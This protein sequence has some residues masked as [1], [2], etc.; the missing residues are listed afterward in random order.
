MSFR[1]WDH[2]AENLLTFSFSRHSHHISSISSSISN[3]NSRRPG[4]KIFKS[5]SHL[6]SRSDSSRARASELGP[7]YF[8]PALHGGIL[9]VFHRYCWWLQSWTIR[10]Q[11]IVIVTS[12]ARCIQPVSKWL[13]PVAIVVKDKTSVLSNFCPSTTWWFLTSYFMAVDLDFSYPIGNGSLLVVC[14]SLQRL[15]HHQPPSWKTLSDG[16]LGSFSICLWHFVA[17]WKLGRGWVRLG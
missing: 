15:V 7:W 10:H 5:D 4:A 13:E 2:R 9:P 12:P 11:T 3:S 14:V 1:K 17:S 8:L 6:Q 16:L